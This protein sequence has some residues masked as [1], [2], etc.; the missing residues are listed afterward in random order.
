MVEGQGFSL[1]QQGFIDIEARVGGAE[2]LPSVMALS[3][4]GAMPSADRDVVERREPTVN[5]TPPPDESGAT[6]HPKHSTMEWPIGR[7]EA[8]L[9]LSDHDRGVVGSGV[10]LSSW[11]GRPR[12]RRWLAH[13]V[14][15]S[16]IH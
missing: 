13:I 12:G 3:G 6:A 11:R 15:V 1:L 10:L 16:V 5:F 8:C 9:S 14:K 7:K 4:E 2:D